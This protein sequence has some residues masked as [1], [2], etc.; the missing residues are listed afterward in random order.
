MD[1]ARAVH[2][3]VD[4]VVEKLAFL[5]G[6]VSPGVV[7]QGAPRRVDDRR[8]RLHEGELLVADDGVGPGDV[9]TNRVT[10][11]EQLLRFGDRLGPEAGGDLGD[12][13]ADVVHQQPAA[14][15]EQR[16]GALG[17]L[18]ADAPEPVEAQAGALH[19]EAADHPRVATVGHP[20]EGIGALHGGHP[21]RDGV[22]GHRVHVHGGDG[23]Q[24]PVAGGAGDVDLVEPH[25]PPRHDPQFVGSGVE[26]VGKR[27]AVGDDGDHALRVRRGQV[28]RQ[29]FHGGELA[30]S[31][32]ACLTGVAAEFRVVQ[33]AAD[34]DA[35]GP[36]ILPRRRFLC[37][38]APAD[39]R[40]PRVAP[41]GWRHARETVRGRY[42]QVLAAPGVA[43]IAL[44]SRPL[45]LLSKPL[46]QRPID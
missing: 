4:H 13:V 21:L 18:L 35:H 41:C 5:D 7:H 38:R 30:Q 37:M 31:T 32:D 28:G 16:D 42:E 46:G 19:I 17:H 11:P 23:D 6:A 14:L 40:S 22:F 15:T 39:R 10:A 29:I 2:R 9:Q 20:I 27:R 3:V 33:L 25:A 43:V 34:V 26:V 45:S 1:G 12:V 44:K 36:V 8:V 24:H